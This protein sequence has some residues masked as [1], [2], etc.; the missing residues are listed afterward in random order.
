MQEFGEATTSNEGMSDAEAQ[1]VL[2]LHLRRSEGTPNLSVGDVAEA[3]HLPSEEVR[4]L[5]ADVRDEKRT[6][7]ALKAAKA[8]QK[9][10]RRDVLIVCMIPILVLLMVFTTAI[11]VSRNRRLIEEQNVEAVAGPSPVGA[12]D[13]S[14]F[15]STDPPTP[16]S[17]FIAS[18][19]GLVGSFE[20]QQFFIK[21]AVDPT[22]MSQNDD[23]LKVLTG[24]IENRIV[25]TVP[26]RV[27]DA[28][29][30]L[31]AI[32]SNNWD[33]EGLLH[34]EL[35]LQINGSDI[36]YRDSMPYVNTDYAPLKQVLFDERVKRLKAMLEM[37]EAKEKVAK[38]ISK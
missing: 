37:L 5:L 33:P 36:S 24:E 14:Q 21:S 3:I 27:E 20:G 4:K 22:K 31:G 23:L 6:E 8:R 11:I 35:T 1:A 13:A 30:M 7:D 38:G 32:R 34:I 29:S 16:P 2:R 12:H 26:L 15:I 25:N 19:P 28:Q 9:R 17:S 10:N 18:G